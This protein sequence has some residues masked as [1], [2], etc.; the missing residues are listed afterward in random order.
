VIVDLTDT[1]AGAIAT[2]LIDARRRAGVPA[3]GMVLTLVI[4]TSEG[5]H[6]DALRAAQDAAREHPSRIVVT[7]LRP[8]GRGGARLDAE[9]R[10]L[11][12]AGP[13]ETVVLRLNGELAEHAESVLLPLL[14]PDAPVVAWWP[15]E[16]PQV[17]ADDPVGAL[18]QRRVTDAAAASDP[19]AALVAR[20]EG[21]RPGDTDLSWTR[22]TG[23]RTLLAAAL[24][25]PHAQVL[26]AQVA[27][28]AGSPSAVLL[29]A[30]LSA[31]F[32]VPVTRVD[33]P[34]PGIT[35][36]RLD[37]AD[38]PIEVSRPDGRLARLSRPGEPDRQV[39]LQQRVTAEILAEEMRR[40]DPDDVYAWVVGQVGA[41]IDA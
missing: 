20:A 33:S 8:G 35:E 27:C 12:D 7:I 30:W 5:E 17:P 3:T 1:T 25:R 40:L 2:A 13:G 14:L 11:G 19:M 37:T 41:G 32:T 28:E 29:A 16:A 6:Y 15:G 24:D 23:W 18:A 31:C 39:A 4:V 22:L 21:Y 10:F 34:G 38:G 26:G 36:V 9:V